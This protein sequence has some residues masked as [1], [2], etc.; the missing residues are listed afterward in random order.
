MGPGRRRHRGRQEVEQEEEA[1]APLVELLSRR[2]TVRSKKS[3]SR[4][5]DAAIRR[6]KQLRVLEFPQRCERRGL[7]DT[8]LAARSHRPAEE[9][10]LALSVNF[11]IPVCCD[12]CV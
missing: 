6:R 7:L 10:A 9:H 3:T 11:K 4:R 5:H 2:A 1:A 12:A 8:S